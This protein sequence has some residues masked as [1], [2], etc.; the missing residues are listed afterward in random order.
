[1]KTTHLHIR[2]DPKLMTRLKKLAKK[3]KESVSAVVDSLVEEA[4]RAARIR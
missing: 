1:M 2:F 3:R 4:C